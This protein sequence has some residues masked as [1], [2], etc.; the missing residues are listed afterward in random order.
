MNV[1]SYLLTCF[2]GG[3]MGVLFFLAGFKLFDMMTPEWDFQEAFSGKVFTG[4]SIVVAAY[5]LGL[6]IVISRAAS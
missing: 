4:G 1:G 5:L 6:A 2:A 3:A